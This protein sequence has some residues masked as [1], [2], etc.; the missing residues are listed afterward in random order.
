[1]ATDFPSDETRPPR[2]DGPEAVKFWRT[3]LGQYHAEFKPWTNRCTK[4]IRRYRDERPEAT[5]NLVKFNVLWSNVETLGPAIYSRPPQPIVERRYLDQDLLANVASMTLER[6]IETQLDLGKFNERMK[7]AR[8]DY[9][10]CGR[11]QLWVRYEPE[12]AYSDPP[13]TDTGTEEEE[14]SEEQAQEVGWEKVC[15]DYVHW[16]DFAHSTARVWE[17]VWWVARR[18]WVSR[19]EGIKRWGSFFGTIGLQKPGD[20]DADVTN[21]R[22]DR[23]PKAEVWEIWDKNAR[24]VIFM[25]ADYPDKLLEV[26]D[27]PLHL[28]GFWPCPE[29]LY[30]TTTNDTLVPVPDYAEYQDQA[31]EIDRLT[32]RI[33][34]ITAAIKAVGLYDAAADGSNQLSRLLQEGTDNMMLPV[35][36][37]AAFAEKGGLQ[38]TVDF[39]PIKDL[40]AALMSLYE[41]RAAAKADLFE[42]TGM[43]DII[44]GQSTGAAKTATEQRI[45]GQFASM[46]LED[47]RKSV[48]RFVRDAIAIVGEIIAEQFSPEI[49]VEMTGMLPVV[50]KMLPT[51]QEQ[52]PA[53]QKRSNNRGFCSSLT[54]WPPNR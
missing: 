46:R 32:A 37:W 39:L 50:K 5:E 34:K 7:G 45:K 27:D 48:A 11:A 15:V 19:Q 30:A 1:M 12:Y 25:A 28:T 36:G 42:I 52:P 22:K 38:G 35:T 8:L 33:A 10:L 47:R 40:V 53:P 31:E 26:A 43:S 2:G 49:L 17:E 16:S 44:R 20:A 3:Q 13:V 23:S 51:P 18:C 6:G 9:L 41:A 29:P 24:Q 4:I 54:P 14:A 21:G